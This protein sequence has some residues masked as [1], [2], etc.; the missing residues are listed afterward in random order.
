MADLPREVAGSA[1]K[2]AMNVDDDQDTDKTR[3]IRY[4][5]ATAEEAINEA[6]KAVAL[7]AVLTAVDREEFR[8]DVALIREKL[9]LLA[10]MI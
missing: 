10:D 7:A 3:A 4:Q 2:L 9:D 8:S 5:L 1:R 6:V